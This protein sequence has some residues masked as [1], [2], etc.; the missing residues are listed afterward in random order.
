MVP[1]SYDFRTAPDQQQVLIAA[2]GLTENDRVGLGI[3]VSDRAWVWDDLEPIV[4]GRM[5]YD[6]LRDF[7][8]RFSAQPPV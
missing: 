7:R 8:L 6:R 4:P 5:L 2:K 3:L 1:W